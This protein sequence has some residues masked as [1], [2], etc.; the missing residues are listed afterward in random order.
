[1]YQVND[2]VLY[3]VH[4]VCKILEIQVQTVNRKKTEYFVLEP[5]SQQ[6][7]RFFVPTQSQVAVSKLRCLISK[8]E[9]LALLSAPESHREIWLDDEN[10]RKQQYKDV[11][12][13]GDRATLLCLLRLLERHREMQADSG[14]KFHISDA[15]F[16]RDAQK[17]IYSEFSLVLD[18]TNDTVEQYIR[19]L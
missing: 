1:M 2:L 11:L 5:I 14:K 16:M 17:M 8:D 7:S 18:T 19:T 12:A 4:G 9:I 15:N 13:T 3:G 10:Q 6:G